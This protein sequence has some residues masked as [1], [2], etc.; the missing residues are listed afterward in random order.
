[1]ARNKL[2]DLNN[3]LFEQIERLNDDELVGEA[4]E[5]EIK[6]AKAIT[7]VS[8]TIVRNAEVMLQGQKYID[9]SFGN[10]RNKEVTRVLIG[11]YDRK[12]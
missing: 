2:I 5:E 9:S 4:L 12:D 1:M 6:K 8:K 7:D 10:V 11:D 3:H